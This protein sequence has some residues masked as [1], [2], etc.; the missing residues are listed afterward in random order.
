MVQRRE[1]FL[2]KSEESIFHLGGGVEDAAHTA[3]QR[4][5]CAVPIAV[6]LLLEL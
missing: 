6:R 4:S 1:S 5:L 3:E 2:R